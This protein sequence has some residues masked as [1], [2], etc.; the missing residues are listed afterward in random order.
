MIASEARQVTEDMFLAAAETLAS[1]VSDD[2]YK[3]GRLYPSLSS[4]RQISLEI[5]VAVAEVAFKDRLASVQQPDDIKAYIQSQMFEPQ[6][7]EYV[8]ERAR[9]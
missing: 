6:Y 5:A 3:M 9:L 7:P 4:I 1:Q 8:L 2:D